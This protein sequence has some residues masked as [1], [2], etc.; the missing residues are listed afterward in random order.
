MEQKNYN[1]EHRTDSSVALKIFVLLYGYNICPS[2]GLSHLPK[3]RPCAHQ[4]SHSPVL[5]A[6]CS[7]SLFPPL[8]STVRTW[9]K[10]NL[11][12][13]V[14]LSL[15]FHTAHPFVQHGALGTHLHHHIDCWETV[16]YLIMAPKYKCSDLEIRVHRKEASICS[17]KSKDKAQ[18]DPLRDRGVT[19]SWVLL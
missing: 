2:P 5:S 8:N 7:H 9:R 18:Q 6:P 17:S 1:F 16:L 11:T 10:W 4:T 14:V 3:L 15:L 13:F 19:V 12:A